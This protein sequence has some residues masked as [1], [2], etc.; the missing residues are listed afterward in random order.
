[1]RQGPHPLRGTM[2]SPSAE[3]Q[4]IPCPQCGAMFG[5]EQLTAQ[6]SCPFCR[7]PFAVPA[8]TLKRLGAYQHTVGA[9]LG[10]AAHE[11]AGTAM[12]AETQSSGYA[13]QQMTFTLVVFGV[14]AVLALIA[15]G[16]LPIDPRALSFIVPAAVIAFVGYGVWWSLKVGRT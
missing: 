8:E 3:A 13:R 5:I 7:Q 12:W 11:Q 6:V 10:A 4:T 2:P 15:A 9:K 1:M 16:V 14:G